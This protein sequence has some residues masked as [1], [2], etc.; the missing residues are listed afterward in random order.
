MY[1]L[2]RRNLIFPFV[3]PVSDPLRQFCGLELDFCSY[4]VFF[5]CLF[6]L[7]FTLVRLPSHWYLNKRKHFYRYAFLFSPL[8]SGLVLLSPRINYSAVSSLSISAS[9][10][11]ERVYHPDNIVKSN[12]E[13]AD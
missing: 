5:V 9:V 1:L 13:A 8:L 11:G 3:S 7:N 2:P 10:L 4:G 12:H 6:V